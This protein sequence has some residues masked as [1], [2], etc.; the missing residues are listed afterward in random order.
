MAKQKARKTKAQG[1]VKNLSAKT[2]SVH[3]ARTVKGGDTKSPTKP[4]TKTTSTDKYLEV[5]LEQTL[6]SS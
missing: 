2:L 3:E 4:T 1:G 5:K 6:I